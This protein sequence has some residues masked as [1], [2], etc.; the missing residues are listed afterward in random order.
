MK[1]G[2]C[3]FSC[4]LQHHCC[5]SWR[6]RWKP[7]WL[8]L[9]NFEGISCLLPPLP[10]FSDIAFIISIILPA[11]VHIL[12]LSI[13]LPSKLNQMSLLVNESIPLIVRIW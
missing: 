12:S 10:N 13:V 9:L 4:V 11:V 8:F 6:W 7:T 3:L 5:S 1:K 2:A